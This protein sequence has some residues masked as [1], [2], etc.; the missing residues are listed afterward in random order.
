MF[1]TPTNTATGRR[2][3]EIG[4]GTTTQRKAV[5]TGEQD[6]VAELVCLNERCPAERC[7]DARRR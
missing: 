7:G 6:E 3:K 5:W 4:M 1:P 2:G